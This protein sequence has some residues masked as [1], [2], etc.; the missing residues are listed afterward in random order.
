MGEYGGDD[1]LLPLRR[2]NGLSKSLLPLRRWRVRLI[3]VLLPL[4]VRTGDCT[5]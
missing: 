2:S 1:V 3:K 5:S 4:S